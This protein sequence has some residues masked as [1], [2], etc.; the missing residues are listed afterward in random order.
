MQDYLTYF[1][2]HWILVHKEAALEYMDIGCKHSFSL[3]SYISVPSCTWLGVQSY[4]QMS[5]LASILPNVY[6]DEEWAAKVYLRHC[7]IGV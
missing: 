3:S 4:E 6:I 7:K 2:T 1:P 5:L